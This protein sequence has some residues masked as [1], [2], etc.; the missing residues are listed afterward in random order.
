M[1]DMQETPLSL[2]NTAESVPCT[3]QETLQDVQET[4]QDMQENLQNVQAF[5]FRE[6]VTRTI[7][8]L[9][10]SIFNQ[11]KFG[12]VD[13]FPCSLHVS[14]GFHDESFSLSLLDSPRLS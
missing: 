14:D 7:L 3:M 9:L 2:V 8:A 13:F 6:R 4:M 11:S 12:S 5:R 1:Q 10:V